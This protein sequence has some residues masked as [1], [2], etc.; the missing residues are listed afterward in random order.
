MAKTF[1]H[2]EFIAW[3]TES[4]GYRFV[5]DGGSSV[6]V[7]LVKLGDQLDNTQVDNMLLPDWINLALFD[8]EAFYLSCLLWLYRRGVVAV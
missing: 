6:T 1:E 7:S 3:R 8:R 2:R 5:Y 4:H